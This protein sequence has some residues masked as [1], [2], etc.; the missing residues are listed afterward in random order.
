[1]ATEKPRNRAN[2]FAG[3]PN[4]PARDGKRDHTILRSTATKSPSQEAAMTTAIEHHYSSRSAISGGETELG[5]PPGG[6]TGP[7]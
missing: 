5:C 3:N 6:Y 4:L 7:R 1:M 2:D